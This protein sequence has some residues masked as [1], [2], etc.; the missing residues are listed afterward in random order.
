MDIGHGHRSAVLLMYLWSGLISLSVLAVGLINGRLVV[1]LILIGIA[2]LFLATA[3]PRLV[4]RRR[5]G[6]AAEH[7]PVP[8]ADEPARAGDAG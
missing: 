4:E 7:E 3:L 1:G 2:F 5:N 8:P 6:E